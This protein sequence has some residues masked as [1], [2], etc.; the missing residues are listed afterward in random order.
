M[1]SDLLCLGHG[2]EKS[3]FKKLANLIQ[4]L[5]YVEKKLS[6]KI[7][8]LTESNSD[9]FVYMKFRCQLM[10]ENIHEQ[11]TFKCCNVLMHLLNE[12]IP[13]LIL[14]YLIPEECG[15]VTH[16]YN[17][18]FS[19]HSKQFLTWTKISYPCIDNQWLDITF[20]EQPMFRDFSKAKVRVCLS[21]ESSY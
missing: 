18:F 2:E 9:C 10:L 6:F 1:H 15:N 20:F 16:V 13:S 5:V 8:K 3:H 17:V 19:R 14:F 12:Y 4:K 11:V 7:K 21:L